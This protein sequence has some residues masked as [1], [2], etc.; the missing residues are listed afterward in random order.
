M[1]RSLLH[2][3]VIFISNPMLTLLISISD[4][5]GL[6]SE[7][8]LN[9]MEN[10]E[11]HREYLLTVYFLSYANITSVFLF[12][13]ARAIFY[14]FYLPQ[15]L[16]LSLSFYISSIL[17]R[18]SCKT[19]LLLDC[20]SVYSYCPVVYSASGIM[21]WYYIATIAQFWKFQNWLHATLLMIFILLSVQTK[22]SYIYF[23]CFAGI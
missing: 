7:R 15:L 22:M 5:E 4:W 20:F 17:L 13:Y 8:A 2:I 12:I 23:P 3:H 6:S 9:F 1:V 21:W 18:C 10:N 11:S 14:C 16:K 19:T